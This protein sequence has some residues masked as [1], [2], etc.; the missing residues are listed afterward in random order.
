MTAIPAE[1]LHLLLAASLAPLAAASLLLLTGC[2]G[3]D[4][5]SSASGSAAWTTVAT[6]RSDSPP[7]QGMESILVSDP[8]SATG[9]ARLVLEMPDVGKFEGLVGMVIPAEKATDA[10][11]IL[12]AVPDGIS[13][14]IV[15]AAPE[16]LVPDLDG[17]YVFVNSV[18]APKA[19]TLEI[20]TKE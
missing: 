17:T 14:I 4:S 19:W 13:V 18:P 5:S 2:S 8:F 11:A 7:F 10:R 15:G 1:K 9:E 3:S 20:Q 6:L 16:H 12:A